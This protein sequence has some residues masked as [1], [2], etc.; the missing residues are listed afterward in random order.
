MYTVSCKASYHNCLSTTPRWRTDQKWF[1]K[2]LSWTLWHS[3]WICIPGKKNLDLKML[4]TS[5]LCWALLST[6]TQGMGEPPHTSSISFAMEAWYAPMGAIAGIELL[7]QAVIW[8][9]L[10]LQIFIHIHTHNLHRTEQNL[11]Q[12][13]QVGQQTS[14]WLTW[15]IFCFDELFIESYITHEDFLLRPAPSCSVLLRPPPSRSG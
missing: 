14:I 11:Q 6:R 5:I 13:G 9:E 8:L 7:D 15:R 10:G 2:W 3:S 12:G 4:C 1:P